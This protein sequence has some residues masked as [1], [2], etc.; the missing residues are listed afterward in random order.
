MSG[1]DAEGRARDSISL[2][3]QR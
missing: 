3:G 1:K 2:S